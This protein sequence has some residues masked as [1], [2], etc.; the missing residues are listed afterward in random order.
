[1]DLAEGISTSLGTFFVIASLAILLF[2]IVLNLGVIVT[3]YSGSEPKSPIDFYILN[4]AVC[5]IISSLFGT[6]SVDNVNMQWNVGAG[7]CKVSYTMV[8]CCYSVAIVTLVAACIERYYGIRRPSRQTH[9][10]VCRKTHVTIP[11]IWL[12]SAALFVVYIYA[13]GVRVLTINGESKKVCDEVWEASS[14]KYFFLVVPFLALMVLP[15]LV[16]AWVWYMTEQKLNAPRTQRSSGGNAVL[17]NK[18]R[19]TVRMLQFLVLMHYLCWGPTI[20]LKL[21]NVIGSPLR[22]YWPVWT[23]LELAHYARPLTNPIIYYYLYSSFRKSL[24][25]IVRACLPCFDIGRD[26][27]KEGGQSTSSSYGSD[28]SRMYRY[29]DDDGNDYCTEM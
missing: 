9:A 14:K 16:V 4:L 23:I 2:C 22:L 13:Y 3:V 5:D 6:I 27:T 12:V 7:F 26:S 18:R 19:R 24:S 1:M 11:I 28:G 15:L 17:H 29:P 20:V 25:A 10:A 8:Y 21:I